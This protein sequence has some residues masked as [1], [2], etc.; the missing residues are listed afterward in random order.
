MTPHDQ[1]APRCLC[2]CDSTKT[3]CWPPVSSCCSLSQMNWSDMSFRHSSLH[4]RY[5]LHVCISQIYSFLYQCLLMNISLP[6]PLPSSLCPSLLPSLFSPHSLLPSS[7]FSLLFFFSFSLTHL[8]LS[9]SSLSSSFLPHS[10]LFPPSSLTLSPDHLQT[11]PELPP[12]CQC[13]FG[14]P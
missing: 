6:P 10:L 4:Y 14:C 8:S 2:A 12:P 1:S 11:R 13:W 9:P 5:T 7:L 3:T